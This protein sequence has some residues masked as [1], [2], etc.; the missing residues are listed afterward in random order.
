MVI[1]SPLRT[2]AAATMHL[3]A[4]DGLWRLLEAPVPTGLTRDAFPQAAEAPLCPSVVSRL[5]QEMKDL[6]EKPSEGITVRGRA[7]KEA[8]PRASALRNRPRAPPRPPPAAHQTAHLRARPGK[9]ALAPGLQGLQPR[10]PLTLPHV[11]PLRRCSST[12]TTWLTL[13][14]SWRA[15]VRGA[16]AGASVASHF[17]RT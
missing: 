7:A 8:L 17:S 9:L 2:S 12:R 1:S 13:A 6:A 3:H 11:L 5:M 15:Q 14:L 10:P 4:R 16:R